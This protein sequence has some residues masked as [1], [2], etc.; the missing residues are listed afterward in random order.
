M[1]THRNWI[2][3]IAVG[4]L[5]TFVGCSPT[6]EPEVGLANE[7]TELAAPTAT[8]ATAKSE[9]VGTWQSTD[10]KVVMVFAENG[11]FKIETAVTF[12][13]M[14]TGTKNVTSTESGTWIS[15]DSKL[16]MNYPA[17]GYKTVY[18]YKVT[19]VVLRLLRNNRGKPFLYSKQ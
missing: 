6:S 8:D 10:G 17:K 13:A 16:A 2:W 1:C 15:A 9:L 3:I 4:A 11:S 18:T 7:A 12:S 14:G 19:G 5:V